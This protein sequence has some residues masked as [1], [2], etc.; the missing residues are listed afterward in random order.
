[1]TTFFSQQLPPSGVEQAAKQIA[2]APATTHASPNVLVYFE[3]CQQV[4]AVTT[5]DESYRGDNCKIKSTRVSSALYRLFFRRDNLPRIVRSLV[6]EEHPPRIVPSLVMEE[7]L[8]ADRTK[9]HPGR[10]PHRESYETSIVSVRGF[11]DNS[12]RI[13]PSLVLEEH[14]TAD[15]IVPRHGSVPHRV[16]YRA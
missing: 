16:S 11:S 1:M 2:S 8:T 15:R 4:G 14:L 5:H 9:P 13:V 3:K 10:A 6:L 12:P 7:H